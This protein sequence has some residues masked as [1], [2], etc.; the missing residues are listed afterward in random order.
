MASGPSLRTQGAISSRN[1][2]HAIVLSAFIDTAADQD[3]SGEPRHDVEDGQLFRVVTGVDD[4]LEGQ[5][6]RR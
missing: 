6:R 2:Q 5:F 1:E 4:E 3:D